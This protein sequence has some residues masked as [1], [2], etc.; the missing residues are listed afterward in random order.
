MKK[1]IKKV[2]MGNDPINT[3]HKY[4]IWANGIRMLFDVLLNEHSEKVLNTTKWQTEVDMYMSIWYGL[5]YTVIEGWIELKLQDSIIEELI[6]HKNTELLKRYRNGVFHFQ[7]EDN[8]T[9]FENFF[10]EEAAANWV[11]TLNREFGRW[12]LNYY[13]PRTKM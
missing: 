11:R 9:R 1:T 7:K 12:F 5:L 3:L 10:S 6:K 4:Y 2:D 8:D 13:A